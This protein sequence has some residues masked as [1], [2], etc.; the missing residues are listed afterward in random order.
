[1]DSALLMTEPELGPPHGYRRRAVVVTGSAALTP[2]GLEGTRAAAA[3]L[4]ERPA[5]KRITEDLA[6]KLDVAR[7]R[8]L[9]RPARVQAILTSLAMAD[10]G[11]DPKSTRV[12]LVM[13][14][15]VGS[16]DASAAFM[17]RV[18]ERGPRF[19]S[20]ADFPNLVPSS[21]VGHVSIYSGMEG[22][23]LATADLDASGEAAAFMAMEL[24]AA[25]LADAALGGAFE[26]ES[27]I[28][29]RRLEVLH[30]DR[31]DAAEPRRS[32][33]EGAGVVLFESEE[34]ARARGAGV[35]A[36]VRGAWSFRD[37]TERAFASIA[38]P[39]SLERAAVVAGH[40]G[41]LLASALDASAWRTARASLRRRRRWRPRGARRSR[42]SL[43]RCRSSR[44]ATSTRSS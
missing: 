8:R 30:G 34:A 28:V 25:G 23:V 35:I 33:A 7:A 22:P 37:L 21:P 31:A 18:F 44:R 39:T 29:E 17:H 42:L 10:A 14:S 4:T 6:A 32:R 26:E 13:G 11:L 9:D 15:A 16:L 38:A 41:A 1:M 24:V 3:T 5:G 12:G 19:A 40:R 43:R 36:V 20:P 27:R 2:A